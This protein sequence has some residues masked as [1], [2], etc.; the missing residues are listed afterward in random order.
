MDMEST[1]VEALRLCEERRQATPDWPV[2]TSIKGQLEYLLKVVRGEES[3]DRLPEVIVGHQAEREFDGED[4][5][6]RT[7]LFKVS[8]IAGELGRD[9]A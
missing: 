1:I 4:S 6:L 7:V 5:E 8:E 2:L 9:S 3:K